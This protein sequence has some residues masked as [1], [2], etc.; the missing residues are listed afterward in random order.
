[1]PA[2]LGHGGPAGSASCGLP[3]LCPEKPRKTQESLL[4]ACF[5]LLL[6]CFSVNRVHFG[7]GNL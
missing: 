6:I 3:R 2:A 4:K 5:R 7:G 1:M